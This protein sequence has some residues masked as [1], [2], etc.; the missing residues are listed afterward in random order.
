MSNLNHPYQAQIQQLEQKIRDSQKLLRDPELKTLAQEEIKRLEQQ[1][2]SLEKA[3]ADYQQQIAEQAEA[4]TDSTLQSSAILELRAGA[5][6]DEA[7]IWADDL[8]RMYV[9][10]AQNKNLKVEFIDDSVIKI[11]GKTKLKLEQPAKPDSQDKDKGNQTQ[12]R[13]HTSTASVAVLPEIKAQQIKIKEEDLEWEFMRS[14]GAGGQSVNKTSSAVRLTHKPSGIVVR[15][16]QERKQTQNRQIALDLLRSQLWE[17][18]EEK[19]EQ[20]IGQA[21]SAIGRS[22]RAEKIRTYNYPQNRVTDHR[23]NQSWYNLES[24]LEGEL[25]LIIST[26]KTQLAQSQK[27]QNE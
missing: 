15:V 10:Y 19:R 7:K 17:I 2:A 6:G 27:S 21:R 22:M 13:I 9:R 23:I 24:V 1:K 14:S 20:K 5:G 3:A 8:L 18:A 25:D 12:G 4:Q 26:V 11:S 16:S